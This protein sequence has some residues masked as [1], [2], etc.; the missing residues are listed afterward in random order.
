MEIHSYI[1][2]TMSLSPLIIINC[3]W[4]KCSC[5]KSC[6]KNHLQVLK[7]CNTDFVLPRKTVNWT[8][9]KWKKNFL[10]SLLSKWTWKLSETFFVRDGNSITHFSILFLFLS[11][12]ISSLLFLWLQENFMI[13]GILHEYFCLYCTLFKTQKYIPLYSF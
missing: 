4:G 9:L 2:Q 8:G 1:K 6:C 10:S 12:T 13:N 7:L 11:F 5:L 3:T